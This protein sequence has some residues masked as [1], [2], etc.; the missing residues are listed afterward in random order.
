[1]IR[2][3]KIVLYVI[4]C[5]L[6]LLLIPTGRSILKDY[7]KIHELPGVDNPDVFIRQFNESSS[8]PAKI[9]LKCSPFAFFTCINNEYYVS[10]YWPYFKVKETL[11]ED[12]DCGLGESTKLYGPN[13]GYRT[14]L[15]DSFWRVFWVGI[16]DCRLHEMVYYGPYRFP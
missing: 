14:L 7:R 13:E 3:F 1:M 8:K 10:P 16:G 2:R 4:P 5:L 15:E 9:V 12:G 11:V 6:L